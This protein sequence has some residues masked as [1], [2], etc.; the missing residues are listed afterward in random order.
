MACMDPP[1]IMEQEQILMGLLSKAAQITTQGSSLQ[2]TTTSGEDLMFE[3]LL[4]EK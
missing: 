3:R 1:G 2:I 4:L